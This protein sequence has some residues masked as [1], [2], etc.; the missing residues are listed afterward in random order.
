MNGETTATPVLQPTVLRWARKR[1]NLSEELLARKLEVPP[2][3]VAEWEITGSISFSEVEKLAEKTF[4]QIGY[5]FLKEPRR[6]LCRFRTFVVSVE[7]RR[8]RPAQTFRCPA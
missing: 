7:V 6:T 1:A 2:E 5:L 3:R 4:T 8:S